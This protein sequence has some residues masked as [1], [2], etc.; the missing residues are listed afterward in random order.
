MQRVLT[1][2]GPLPFMALA[3]FAAGCALGVAI[4]VFQGLSAC[5]A[6]VTSWLALSAAGHRGGGKLFCVWLVA[7]A[8]RTID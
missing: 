5:I 6:G 8:D 4:F 3:I 7:A 1:I 2:I